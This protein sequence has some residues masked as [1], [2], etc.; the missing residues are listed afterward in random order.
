MNKSLAKA[1]EP[2]LFF[3]G[4]AASLK[5]DAKMCVL[6]AVKCNKR[7]SPPLSQPQTCG[8]F[9]YKRRVGMSFLRDG[10]RCSVWRMK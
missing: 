1:R 8:N 9:L 5:A 7:L 6:R 3:V 10:K 4:D 2:M